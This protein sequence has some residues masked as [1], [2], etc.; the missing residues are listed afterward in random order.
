MR[1]RSN[2][3]MPRQLRLVSVLVGDVQVVILRLCRGNTSLMATTLKKV[4]SNYESRSF[5]YAWLGER[6]VQETTS[7][8]HHAMPVG[9]FEN[10]T[11]MLNNAQRLPQQGKVTTIVT[12]HMS[13]SSSGTNLTQSIASPSNVLR[14]SWRVLLTGSTPCIQQWTLRMQRLP[15]RPTARTCVTRIVEHRREIVILFFCWP[16]DNVACRNLGHDSGRARKRV[17]TAGTIRSGHALRLN[18]AQTL[19]GLSFS[20]S[21]LLDRFALSPPDGATFP[22][23]RPTYLGR[24]VTIF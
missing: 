15:L 3:R 20:A 24:H 8:R 14:W 18:T 7:I 5:R 9:L 16:S 22:S 17:R 13:P 23:L 19:H 1:D 2:R 12:I 21:S 4:M 11:C 6:V 10:D